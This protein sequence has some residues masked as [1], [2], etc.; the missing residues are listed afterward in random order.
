MDNNTKLLLLISLFLLLASFIATRIMYTDQPNNTITSRGNNAYARL[1][2]SYTPHEQ[3]QFQGLDKEDCYIKALGICVEDQR[4]IINTGKAA[5]I[6]TC[7][8]DYEVF[9]DSKFCEYAWSA[10]RK[11]KTRDYCKKYFLDKCEPNP[12]I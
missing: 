11:T 6:E 12:K 9:S 7:T 3:H 4:T 2:F 5:F 8:H 1:L 10:F